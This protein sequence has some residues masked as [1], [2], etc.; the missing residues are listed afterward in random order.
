MGSK[1]V[2]WCDRCDTKNPSRLTG[3]WFGT[4]SN[5]KSIN[6]QL[7]VPPENNQ[8]SLCDLCL[9]VVRYETD[10]WKTYKKKEKE[11]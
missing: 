8:V 4:I 7:A 2:N 11:E 1:V 5:F 3:F 10:S 6:G 9:D